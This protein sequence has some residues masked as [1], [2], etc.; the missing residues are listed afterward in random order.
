MINIIAGELLDTEVLDHRVIGQ[1]RWISM[2][3]KG[4]GFS[5]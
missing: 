1:G 3:E 4:L 5:R 2:R